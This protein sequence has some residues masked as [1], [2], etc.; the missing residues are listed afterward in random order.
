M[1][2]SHLVV[3]LALAVSAAFAVPVVS[4]PALDDVSGEI[5]D[6]GREGKNFCPF[7]LLESFTKATLYLLLDFWLKVALSAFLVLIGGVMA[8]L[9]IGLMG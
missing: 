8:G 1:R 9:T 6:M 2:A 7:Q 5:G 3:F 4:P